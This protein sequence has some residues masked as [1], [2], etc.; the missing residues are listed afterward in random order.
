MQVVGSPEGDCESVEG[1]RNQWNVH[2]THPPHVGIN[3][4]PFHDVNDSEHDPN[5][6]AYPHRD[7]VSARAEDSENCEDNLGH[8]AVGQH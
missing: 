4:E 5:V 6:T 8:H 2:D 3:N 7:E 1:Y